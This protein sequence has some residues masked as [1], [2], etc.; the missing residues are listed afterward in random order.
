[1]IYAREQLSEIIEKYIAAL[2]FPAEPKELFAPISYSLE[3]GGKRIRPLLVLMGANV[4]SDNIERALPCAGAIEVFHN[5]T[6]LHDDIMDNAAMRRGKP[7]VQKKWNHNTAILSG[8][9]M[10]IY[11]YT[12]LQQT[13]YEIL[14]KVL[15]EFNKLALEVCEGQQYDMDFESRNDVTIEEYMN[16]IRLKTSVLLAGAAKIGAIAGGAND[17]DCDILYRFGIELGQAFQLQDD[18]L[19]AY[20]MEETL[21]KTVGGDIM[22]AKKTFLTINALN[23]AG[24]ATRRALIAT[25][26]DQHLPLQQKIGRVKTIYNSLDIPEITRTVISEHLT[27]ATEALD[28]LTVEPARTEALRELVQMIRNRDK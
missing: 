6:L 24:G 22:E 14:P 3:G 2:P 11:S 7:S 19:D 23:E 15:H 5:F 9:A 25:L 13:S 8:D 12:L 28:T 26:Q 18:L 16:M 1:M 10:V 27:R 4:F 17:A 20:G 21:G